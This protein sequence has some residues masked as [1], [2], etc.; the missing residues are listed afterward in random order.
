M[1]PSLAHIGVVYLCRFA[2]GER[3]VRAFVDS[4]RAHPAGA[5][6]DLYVIFKG[7]SD[8]G[9]LAAAR[10]L[11]G[12]LPV[13]AI[14]LDDKGY[15]IGAYFA[16]ARLVANRRLIFFNTF[17][18]LLADNWLKKFD[19]ALS[20][21][22]V[23]LVGATGCWQSHRSMY[24][25]SW[26]RA[27]YWI[28]HPLG[29]VRGNDADRLPI[30]DS[31]KAQDAAVPTV[32]PKRG[33]ARRAFGQFARALYHLL[34]FDQ[35]LLPY[36]PYPNPHVR[37]NA[38]MIGR[39]RFLAL[40]IPSLRN[41]FGVYKFE[42]GRGSLTH[43]IIGQGLKTVVVDREGNAYEPADWKASSTYW[44]EDQR[45]LL[46]ADNRTRD[47]S[48]GTPSARAR[49]QAYAWEDPELWSRPAGVNSQGVVEPKGGQR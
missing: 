41:K 18:E 47:Y 38:F 19:D 4:Y 7:F 3:P 27:L 13:Q 39:D 42:S 6:H 46:A 24:Q 12:E 17:T 5:D 10:A 37:T 16:A 31:R 9:S 20:L 36:A 40:R 32:E 8:K 43:Q 2:E 22:D 26:R 48:E 29:Y 33:D 28:R 44:I 21:P 1:E 25:A 15:D 45:N 23:G 34:R 35:L 14:E 11:F 49:L 30:G